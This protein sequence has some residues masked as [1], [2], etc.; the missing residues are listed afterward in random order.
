MPLLAPV[1]TRSVTPT[2]KKQR[3]YDR[4]D[5]GLNNRDSPY[6]IKANEASDC[7]NVEPGETGSCTGR[8]G[9]AKRHAVALDGAV[10]GAFLYR[11][12]GGTAVEIVTAGTKAYKFNAGTGEYD[13]LYTGLTAGKPTEWTQLQNNALMVNGADGVFETD[14]ATMAK[15]TPNAAGD[16]ALND[17]NHPIHKSRFILRHGN[18]IFYISSAAAGFGSYGWY[19]EIADYTYAKTT[20][21]FRIETDDGSDLTG[22][23][24]FYGYI[25]LFKRR[26]I[27]ILSTRGDPTTD[28]WIRSIHNEVGTTSH[29]SIVAVDNVLAFWS[30]G[31]P[32][33][34]RSTEIAE[35]LNVVPLAAKIPKTV[36]A[37]RDPTQ[38]VAFHVPHQHQ[39]WFAV[40][41]DGATND[42]VLVYD[43]HGQSWWPW[44]NMPAGTFLRLDD[45]TILFGKPDA[46]QIYKHTPGVYNDDGVAIRQYFQTLADGMD[47]PANPKAFWDFIIQGKSFFDETYTLDIT[48]E[49][50][51][52][53]AIIR[54]I[55][56]A[57]DYTRWGFNW[58]EAPW[59]GQSIMEYSAALSGEGKHIRFKFENA[60]L[61]ETF[62]IFGLSVLF[63][64]KPAR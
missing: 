57:G 42:H 62:E 48:Y 32:Y 46:G 58:G 35:F 38:V 16:N 63:T 27:H 45:T 53:G 26:S 56:L 47:F 7:L 43:Y 31:G 64:L 40:P 14:G 9:Y 55:P 37:V 4:F 10:T 11:P 12:A 49:I 2:P 15:I 13:V 22:A 61:N 3:R 19:S 28:W 24:I 44:S 39:L 23:A 52:F 8:S 36:A 59:G 1:R 34:L 29:R 54:G 30:D 33:G 6:A 51:G 18:R 25:V 21:F 5:G 41:I 20:S 17:P 50:D 60:K